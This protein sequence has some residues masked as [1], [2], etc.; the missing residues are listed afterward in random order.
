MAIAEMSEI[1]ESEIDQMEMIES[2][3]SSRGLMDLI[4]MAPKKSTV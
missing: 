4:R 3:G 2:I 1:P